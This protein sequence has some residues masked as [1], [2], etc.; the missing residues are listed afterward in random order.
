MGIPACSPDELMQEGHIV[1][2]LH[3]HILCSNAQSNYGCTV[4]EARKHCTA[5][6][7]TVKRSCMAFAQS[8][9]WPRPSL[10]RE[11]HQPPEEKTSH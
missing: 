4:E 5:Q 7:C 6:S 10:G 1:N 11:D 9:A 2:N 8:M 3:V